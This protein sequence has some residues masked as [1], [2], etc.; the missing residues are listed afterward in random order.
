MPSRTAALLALVACML[1]APGVA[2]EASGADFTPGPGTY[3]VDTTA[4]TLTGPATSLTGTDQGGV[5]VFS[6]DNVD[7]PGTATINV[8]GS[9]PFKLL[10]S[11]SLTLA[12]V[13]NGSGTSATDSTAGPNAGGPGGG[14][15]GADGTQPGAG[16]GGGGVSSTHFNGAGGGGFGGT[17]ARGGLSTSS[18][19]GTA[20][21][22]GG[23]YGDLNSPSLQG[24]SGGGGDTFSGGTGGTGG[25]GGGGGIALVGATVTVASSGVVLADG[26]GG[27]VG[28]GAS[29]GGSGGGIV[30]HGNIV[31][32]DGA[33]VARGGPGGA[34]GCCGD[35]GGGGGGRIA[36]QFRTLIAAGTALVSGGSSGTR[37]TGG[38]GHG[39]LSPDATGAAGLVTKVQA[40]TAITG[41]ATAVSSTGATLNGTV[42]PNSNATTYHFDFGTTGAYGTRL[43]VPDASVGSDAADHVVSAAIGGLAPNTTYHYRVVATDAAG[44]TTTGPDVGFT[45]LAA[46]LPLPPATKPKKP[47]T[48][49]S[50][51]KIDAEKGI[52]TFKFKASGQSTGFRCALAKKH[53]KAKFKFKKCSSPKTYKKLKPGKYTFEVRAVGP[54]GTDPSPAKKKFT[55]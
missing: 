43:P 5:A 52:A 3:T 19:G 8:H 42:N 15:G 27:A 54:G 21:V 34:G 17:G 10:A 32:I 33:L 47:K 4:L 41:P 35:G 14:A 7:I 40:A 18:P 29:G 39:G 13:I 20:G 28:T 53:K 48:T 1:F 2:A 50:N 49:L 37:S 26:G 36:Y 45:T 55:I 24:G 25:G 9:R 38:Y 16:P 22:G 31:E 51:A 11:G 6:F 23:S 30:V 12:G 44:F 46:P